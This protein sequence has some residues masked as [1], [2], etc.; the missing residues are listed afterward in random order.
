VSDSVE[1]QLPVSFSSFVISLAQSAM[2]HLGEVPDPA[3]G[4]PAVD[5]PLARNTIDLIGLLKQKTEG[6]LDAEEQRLVET[7]LYELRTRWLAQKG[8]AP[9]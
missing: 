4:Q 7:V 8:G 3:T 5:L 1:R 6:N 9:G 2:M